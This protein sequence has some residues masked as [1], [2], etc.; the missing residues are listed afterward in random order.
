MPRSFAARALP[1]ALLL[2]AALTFAA[3]VRAD[4]EGGGLKLKLFASGFV[5]P[6]HIARP[7]AD[8]HRLFVTEH[9]GMI[10]VVEDGK[11][12]AKPFLDLSKSGLD[13]VCRL[14]KPTEERGLLGLA[15]HPDYATNR[16]FYVDYIRLEDGAS[17][18]CEYLA[19]EGDPNAAEPGERLIFGAVKQPQYNHN[20]GA[21]EFGPDGMLYISLGDGGLRGDQGPGHN[22]AVGNG[23]D[24][25]TF[26][27]KILRI[28]VDHPAANSAYGIPKGNPFAGKQGTDQPEIFAW[29]LRNVW[30]F[31]FD[32]ADGRLFAAD[33]GQDLWEEIDI[34]QAGGNY[35]WRRMEGSHCFNPRH[36]CELPGLIPPIHDYPH[37]P[38][39]NLSITGGYVYRGKAYPMMAGQYVFGDFASGRI[40][41]LAPQPEGEWRARE[42]Y[43]ANFAIS[44]FGQDA[45]GELLVADYLGGVIHRLSFE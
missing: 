34:I 20:G 43:D 22:P 8:A 28:D 6:T 4:G 44:T 15:F 25:A 42:L 11:T 40:W 13:R 30:K 27:G 18:V 21:I 19:S 10:R 1:T 38:G 45:E 24:T 17:V 29:G 41:A 2:A 37:Q 14:G 7:S 3:V 32:R 5:E 12:L 33:V 26:L 31:S 36:E 16:K 23:Q 9:A 35:G 39:A